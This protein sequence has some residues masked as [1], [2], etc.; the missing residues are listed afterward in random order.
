MFE[1]HLRQ[2]PLLQGRNFLA[3]ILAIGAGLLA[4]SRPA[5][6]AQVD[7]ELLAKRRV[8][9]EA[10]AG[11]RAIRRFSAGR[12]SAVRYYVL[13]ATRGAVVVYSMEG[14]RVAEIPPA[15]AGKA[16]AIIYGEDMDIDSAGRV[17]VADRG[18]NAIKIFNA[19]GSLGSSISVRG[20]TSV[21]VLQGGEL[22]VASTSSGRLVT[23]FNLAG[24][25]IREFGEATE[26]SERQ[27]LNRYANIG[28]VASDADSHIY[29]AFSYLPEPTLRKY[30]RFGY[31][32]FQIE[33]TALEFQ[34]TAQAAR[35]EILR[36]ER[37]GAPVL[38]PIVTAF[39]VDPA[40]QEIWI[41]MHGQLLHFARDGNRRASYRTLTPQGARLEVTSILVEPDRLLLSADPLGVYEFARP[42]KTR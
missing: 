39:G 38:K 31:S 3:A 28:R 35:R 7:N 11:L 25:V 27:E 36:L 24:K 14:Q 4:L 37:K 15:S 34:P 26:I 12:D 22:A 13:S 32:S 23:V 8:F 33:L 42:D 1:L 9:P 20:P 40:N 2:L 19:E 30:D 10:G 41:A 16:A 5:V 18:A 21:A 29:Y 6:R 17:Y